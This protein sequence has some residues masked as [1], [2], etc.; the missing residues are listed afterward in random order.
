VVLDHAGEEVHSGH[1]SRSGEPKAPRRVEVHASRR[2]ELEVR[3]PPPPA[4]RRLPIRARERTRERLVRGV[5]GVQRDS[6]DVVVRGQQAV[7]RPLEQD[8]APKRRRRL[9][10]RGRDK[11][12]A[13]EAREVQ[14]RRERLAAGVVVVQRVGEDV[15]EAGER[16]GG[17]AHRPDPATAPARLT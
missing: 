15:D 8:A 16:V 17:G 5:A 12:V 1:L 9:A 7:G 10:R 14:A 2:A 6:Q 11:P 4:R 3:G 13:V